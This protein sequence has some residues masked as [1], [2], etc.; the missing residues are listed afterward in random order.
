MDN[1]PAV[2][3]YK[4]LVGKDSGPR[5]VVDHTGTHFDIHQDGWSS[6]PTLDGLTERQVQPQDLQ[7][8][9]THGLLGEADYHT[10]QDK[11][12]ISPTVQKLWDLM[13][14][15]KSH[16]KEIESQLP[17]KEFNF[18]DVNLD[19]VPDDIDEEQP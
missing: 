5:Y 4:I 14:Q 1:T 8:L 17:E 10:L 15:L 9:V 12:L 7:M 13:A 6:Q 19:D 18:D 2:L 3:R 16:V 11:G